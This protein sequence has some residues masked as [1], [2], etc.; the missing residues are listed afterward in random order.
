[1]HLGSV[2]PGHAA[3]YHSDA[4]YKQRAGVKRET[5][6]HLG[7]SFG[8]LGAIIVSFLLLVL[9]IFRFL[10]FAPVNPVASSISVVL[11]AL[12]AWRL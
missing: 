6:G 12:Q 1:M 5:Q 3:R 11:F 9:P 7:Q 2:A 4:R 8:L 10:N